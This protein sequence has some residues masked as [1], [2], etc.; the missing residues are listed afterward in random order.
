MSLP[1]VNTRSQIDKWQRRPYNGGMDPKDLANNLDRLLRE[2]LMT[3]AELARASGVSP[4]TIN[5]YLKG[6]RPRPSLF[7]LHALAG[8]LG[9]SVDDLSRPGSTGGAPGP[10]STSDV[11]ER[12]TRLERAVGIVA[13]DEV[14]ARVP[15]QHDA[16]RLRV[17]GVGGASPEGGE[18]LPDGSEGESDLFTLVVGGD[19]LAPF[20]EPDDVL[21]MSAS[22]RPQIGDVV[23]VII[24]GE[25]H[26]KVVMQRN[27]V[28]HLESRRGDLKIPSE[29][30]RLE[31]VMIRHLREITPQRLDVI[32]S[33]RDTFFV[34]E[35]E[36]SSGAE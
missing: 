22:K 20:V 33:L 14:T 10:S 27:G 16:E 25:R 21:I 24:H 2:K 35:R 31:G 19:C 28:L 30:A 23:S 6:G 32:T 34:R 26:I 11:E 13:I 5:R 36:G 9:V 1:S 18:T 29:G 17:A 8:T 3:Q 15:P 12:L 4:A 7:H